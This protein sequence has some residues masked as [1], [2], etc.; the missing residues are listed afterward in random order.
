MKE[1][2]LRAI[3]VEPNKAAVECTIENTLES[4]QH[5]VDGWI[6]ITYPFDDDVMVVG[7]EE[8]KLIGLE[9]NRRINGQ[10]YAGNLLL[11]ADDHEGDF[12]SLTDDEVA[13]YLKRFAKPESISSD[14]VQNDIGF[15]IFTFSF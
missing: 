13:K 11:V 9:G 14:D 1:K 5:V 15:Q 3:L 4:L 6:E 10:I 7:N 12:R 8:A 2:M